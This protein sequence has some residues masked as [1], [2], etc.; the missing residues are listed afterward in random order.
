[1][2]F[3]TILSLGCL[4]SLFITSPTQAQRGLGEGRASGLET[5]SQ[6]LD[7]FGLYTQQMVDRRMSTLK[8][9]EDMLS[10]F[11]SSEDQDYFQRYLS[12]VH[13]EQTQFAKIA[14][15]GEKLV[16][17]VG[18]YQLSAPIMN[19]FS[20]QISIND[21][22]FVL[23]SELSYIENMKRL[24]SFIETEILKA[25]KT[26]FIDWFIAPTYA[27]TLDSADKERF[28]NI[29][30]INSNGILYLTVNTLHIW[31]DDLGD[32]RALLTEV[33]NDLRSTHQSCNNLRA[34]VGVSDGTVPVYKMLN[35]AT[36]QTLESLTVNNRIDSRTLMRNAFARYAHER[37]HRHSE[38]SFTSCENFLDSFLTRINRDLQIQASN[39][40]EQFRRTESC[41]SDLNSRHQQV[42]NQSR[43]GSL[44]MY[45]GR[46]R[47][48]QNNALPFI[49]SPTGVSER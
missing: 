31:R 23:N 41:L 36:A 18:P 14:Q 34:Q 48:E 33:E 17:R 28:K 13:G 38:L 32:L 35:R 15:E 20:P 12:E 21:K 11:S 29:L 27:N 45:N 40:C 26:S 44:K 5:Q 39:F 49:S 30:M 47:D 6:T 22:T 2:K 8:K 16:M 42:V 19:M 43:D 10:K 1:M 9:Y 37:N 25:R 4:L 7:G 3:K 46:R 24:E